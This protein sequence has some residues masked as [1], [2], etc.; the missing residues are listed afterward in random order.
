M[1][2]GILMYD[3]AQQVLIWCE[4]G[5]CLGT[6]FEIHTKSTERHKTVCHEKGQHKSS[7]DFG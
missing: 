5:W 4:S 6:M 7:S 3:L 2:T 1:S